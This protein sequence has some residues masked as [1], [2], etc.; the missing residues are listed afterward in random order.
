MS[1]ARTL[2]NRDLGGTASP[3]Q[4]LVADGS[5]GGEPADTVPLVIEPEFV[6]E[7]AIGDAE[8][9]FEAAKALIERGRV[10]DAER[11]LS[12]AIARFP[13]DPHFAIEYARV[14][15]SRDN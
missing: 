5:G 4:S 3:P 10:D 12:E 13:R 11:M 1:D 2:D 14:A 9:L 8:H 7:P 15:Q 6:E